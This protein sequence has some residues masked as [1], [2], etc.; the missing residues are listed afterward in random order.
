M[1]LLPF[2]A[3]A[4]ELPWGPDETWDVCE[5][6]SE[7]EVFPNEAQK[8]GLKVGPPISP[9]RGWDIANAQHQRA[10]FDMLKRH[11]ISSSALGKQ[12]STQGP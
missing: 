3:P 9:V 4:P 5:F 2:D 6:N 7:A 10:L 11:G 1:K 8:L 12:D